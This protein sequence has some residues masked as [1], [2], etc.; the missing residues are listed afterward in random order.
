MTITSTFSAARFDF[1]LSEDLKDAASDEK[2]KSA[3]G[4]KISK[5]RVGEEV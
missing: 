3:L 5:E 1:T 4:C 2:V